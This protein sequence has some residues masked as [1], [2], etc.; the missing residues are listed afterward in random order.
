MKL[1]LEGLES[2]M[3][4]RSVVAN[5]RLSQWWPALVL[6][7][8]EGKAEPRLTFNYHYVFEEPPGDHTELAARTHAFLSLPTHNVFPHIDFKNAY[9]VVEVHL[10]D[11][12]LPS[13]SI[14][15]LGQLQPTCMPQG[16]LSSS[17]CERTK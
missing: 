4:E 8:K 14:P 15:A 2:G 9:W 11:R 12:H 13:L 10:D 6:V 7:K 3:Y 1:V 5:E 17:N 16:A